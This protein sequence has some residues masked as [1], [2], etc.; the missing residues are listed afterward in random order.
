MCRAHC[1]AHCPPAARCPPTGLDAFQ[2]QVVVS[3][4]K[5]LAQAGHTLVTSIHQP[6]SS[7]FALF[8]DLVLLSEGRLA[9]SGPAQVG[10]ARSG[11][12]SVACCC[13]N[14]LCCVL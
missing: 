9:Y 14:W 2:A 13:R 12:S 3:T 10:T 1:P 4:L 11:R 5:A 8:D 7:I 6:R